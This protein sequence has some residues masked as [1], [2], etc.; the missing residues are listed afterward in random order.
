MVEE[1]LKGNEGKILEFKENLRSLP[2]I[3]KTIIAFANTAGGIIVI[4]IEDKTKKIIGVENP[5]AEEERLASVINDSIAP[6]LM[7]DIEIQAYGTK[8]LIIINVPHVIGP[9]YLKTAGIEKGT[10]IRLGSTNRIVDE[11]TLQAL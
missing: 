10:Y 2:G 11:E 1:I 4:G 6:L 9:C 8:E 5:L 7:P 3:I